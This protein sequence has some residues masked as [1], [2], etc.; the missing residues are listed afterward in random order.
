ME[1]LY[2]VNQL[3]EELGITPRALRFYEVKGLLAPNRVGNNRVY[4]KR[5]RARLKL[6]LRG[7]RLGFSLAEI[8]EYL[9]LYNV[10]GGVEQ[11]KNLL[12]R[13]QKR[14]KDLAQQREDLEATVQE[15]RDIEEQVNN[16]LAE[17][18]TAAKDS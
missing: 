8:R 3:A 11:Q 5:D 13:V 7:K 6:I 15:L 16:T 18:K 4:T 9:D 10:N 12:K 2:T 1:Q 17:L 14:L